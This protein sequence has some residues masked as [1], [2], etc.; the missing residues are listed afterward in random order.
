MRKLSIKHNDNLPENLS[1]SDM[2]NIV[3]TARQ[4]IS[5]LRSEME[6]LLIEYDNMQQNIDAAVAHS[7]ENVKV[8]TMKTLAN[9]TA[10]SEL[11]KTVEMIQEQSIDNK[12]AISQLSLYDEAN[13]STLDNLIETVNGLI[14]NVDKLNITTMA[15]KTT[16]AK[17][18]ARIDS[19]E[20]KLDTLIENLSKIFK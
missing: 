1:F 16:I 14:P 2:S 4:E 8:M 6:A 9:K 13:T 5:D 11:K 3:S 10:L 7:D 12:H 19:L 15:N 20:S 17:T 18:N